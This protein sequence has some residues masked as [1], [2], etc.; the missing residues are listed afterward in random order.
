MVNEDHDDDDEFNDV[1]THKNHMCI[2]GI[3][4]VDM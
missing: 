2:S 3:L 4:T 1:S